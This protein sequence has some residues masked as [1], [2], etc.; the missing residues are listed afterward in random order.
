MFI[1][2][3]TL[4]FNNPWRVFQSNQQRMIEKKPKDVWGGGEFSMVKKT[5]FCST[6]NFVSLSML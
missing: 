2:N 1:G 6:G 3:T 4:W 5:E